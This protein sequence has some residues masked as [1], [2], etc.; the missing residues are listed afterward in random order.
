MWDI[1]LSHVTGKHVERAWSMSL[2]YRI[3]TPLLWIWS[4]ASYLN[5]TI[6]GLDDGGHESPCAIVFMSIRN[7]Y[8][9]MYCIGSVP[10]YQHGAVHICI[11]CIFRM[12]WFILFRIY[13][14]F[15]VHPTWSPHDGS[16][17]VWN[18]MHMIFVW[19]GISYHIQ[20]TLTLPVATYNL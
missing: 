5:D 12:Q 20:Q 14:S 10:T 1:I 7:I 18:N 6:G 4:G 16:R 13:S 9:F 15:C 11:L 8:I 17:G 19:V 3:S 2:K